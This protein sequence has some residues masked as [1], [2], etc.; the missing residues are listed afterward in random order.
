[1]ALRSV[2]DHPKFN[3]LKLLLKCNRASALGYLECLWHFTARFTPQG[4]V[5][6]FA[7]ED[8]EAWVE[9]D[10]DEGALIAALVKSRWLDASDDHRLIVHDWHQHADSTVHVELCKKLL[11]F[12]SGDA[13]RIHHDAFNT[14]SRNR[15]RAEFQRKFGRDVWST[16]AP[17]VGPGQVCNSPGPAMDKSPESPGPVRDPSGTRPE[18]VRAIPE[19]EPEPE[20]LSMSAKVSTNRTR[21]APPPTPQESPPDWFLNDP[22][23]VVRRVAE[24][25]ASLPQRSHDGDDLG[26][27]ESMVRRF[28]RDARQVAQ[29]AG[30]T[31][32][33]VDHAIMAM[34]GKFEDSTEAVRR[35]GAPIRGRPLP[36]WTKSLRSWLERQEPEW[37]R[38]VAENAGGNAID[39]DAIAARLQETT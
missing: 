2:I 20:K 28:V 18:K 34:L 15:I 19:P 25:I 9:W 29:R 39:W 33:H 10:G 35:K 5:G 24:I 30:W 4:D 14:D 36:I 16:E 7:D 38:M 22:D 17:S 13:P 37:A 23:R 21:E 6:R 26:A 8:I 12:A 27:D 32:E 3:R 31:G 1:M 11:L